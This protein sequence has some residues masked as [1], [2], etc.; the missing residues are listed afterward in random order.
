MWSALGHVSIDLTLPSTS[1]NLTQYL[2]AG[3]HKHIFHV[4][5]KYKHV[6]FVDLL[7]RFPLLE[8]L[9][10]P[11]YCLQLH[12]IPNQRKNVSHTYMACL[13][14]YSFVPLWHDSFV[15]QSFQ[16]L[17]SFVA[18]R[19]Y[20]FLSWIG[21]STVNPCFCHHAPFHSGLKQLLIQAVNTPLFAPSICQ[22]A[23]FTHY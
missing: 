18:T 13:F 1:S 17:I 12:Y 2:Q 5:Y 9:H 16:L 6:G 19:I 21:N 3:H 7:S 10:S 11:T 15:C 23:K 22:V 8:S 14:P 4:Y 20:Y